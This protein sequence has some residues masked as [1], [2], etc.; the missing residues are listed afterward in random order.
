MKKIILMFGPTTMKRVVRVCICLCLFGACR[1]IDYTKG[2]SDICP[3]HYVRMTRRTV[4]IVYGLPISLL[5]RQ[6]YYPYPGDVEFGG[7]I[8]RDESRAVVYVCHECEVAMKK[9]KAKDR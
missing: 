1:S 5:H 8:M 3:I 4:P 2:Q 9:D 6:Q 7:C